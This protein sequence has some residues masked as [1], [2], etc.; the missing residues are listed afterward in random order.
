MLTAD[1]VANA[2]VASLQGAGFA[3]ATA[4]STPVITDAR[5]RTASIT[6]TDVL[7][8]NGVIHVIDRVILPPQ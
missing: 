6:G 4:G 7:N 2:T 1:I 8:S 3:I 5:G